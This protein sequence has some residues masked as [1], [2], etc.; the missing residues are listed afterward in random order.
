MNKEFNPKPN[1]PEM[2]EN[3]LKFWEDNKIFEKSLEQTK[4][5]KPFV[6]FE[7][8]PTANAKPALHHVE[9]RAFKDLIPRYQT[10]RGRFVNRKAGWDTHGLPVELQI[11]KKLQISGKKQIESIRPTVRESIIEFNRLCKQSV[12]EYK[13]DWEKLT[14]RMGYWVDMKN[15]YI[16]YHNKYI[17]SIWNI[18]KQAWDKDLVYLGHKV[19]PYCTRCGT[20]L[21]SHEVA[22]GYKTVK[23]NSVYV[24]FKLKNQENT[25]ILSWTTTPWTLPG[26]VALAVGKDIE[27][28]KVKVGDEFWILAKERLEA[29]GENPEVV[30]SMKGKDLLGLEYEPLFE[31]EFLKTPQSYKIYDADFVTTTDGTGVVHTAVVY[32]EDDYQLGEKVGL[33]KIHTVNDAGLFVPEV[34]ELAGMY[35]KDEA[36]EGKIFG[37]LKSH[38][39]FA[40]KEKY[41]H[42]YPHCWRCDTPLLYYARE[43]WFIK[44]SQLRED[45]IKNNEQ[46]TW[47]PSHIKYGRFGNWL[48]EI[49]DWAISRERYWGTPLPIWKCE[50]C[51][52]HQIIGSVDELKLNKNHFYIARHGEAQNVVQ[53]IHMHYP[54]T[55]PMP[56]TELGEKQ[57]HEL[58]EKIKALGGVDMIFASD[59]VRTKQTAE[60]A[61]K[62]L[63]VEVQFD[64]RLREF[65]TGVYNGKK[66]EEYHKDWPVQRRWQEAPE[67]GESYMDLQT[68]M[69]DFV[70]ELNSKHNGK[71]ILL[72]THG[73]V[74]WLMNQYYDVANH[75]PQV[76]EFTQIELGLTDLHRPYIDEVVLPCPYCGN[77]SKRV[78]SVLDVWFDSGAMPYAQW[79]AP[80]ENA[81]LARQQFP[82][83]FISEAID[84]TRGWFYT[85]LAIS[86]ILGKG[87]AYKHVICLG[88]LLD[89]KG[90][91]MSKSKGNIIDPWE[92]MNKQG[93]DAVRWYMYSIN[94][95]GD[96]KLFAERDLD[97]IVRKNFLTLWNVL[98]FFV[99]YSSFDKW[100]PSEKE[101]DALDVLDQWILAKT[102]ELVNSVTESL[103]NFDAFRAS[104]SIEDFINELS[105]WYVRRSRERKGPAVYQ[106]LYKVL[107]TLSL[108]MAPFTPFLAENIWQV[109][110]Q[111]N[112]AESVHL[113]VWPETRTLSADETELL[114]AM[115]AVREAAS[116][117]LNA[118][119]E[120]GLP[121]RQPLSRLAVQTKADVQLSPEL[122]AILASEVNVKLVDDKLVSQSGELVKTYAGTRYVQHLY[123]DTEI[124]PELKLEGLAR[125]LERIVQDMRKKSGLKVGE[126]VNLAYDTSDE[127][128]AKAMDLFDRK[129]T[130]VKEVSAK[131]LENEEPVSLDG[132]VI[133]L[134]IEK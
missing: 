27:Y 123:L 93:V 20:A 109:L 122:A 8:P 72:V 58:G 99:T 73:D 46:I 71:K 83:D 75:Y 51:K 92:P 59:L 111:E 28:A 124:S 40:R 97:L 126:M 33:P 91:K 35:V 131:N 34:K 22:Q 114:A 116:V 48:A 55:T 132:K 32:G 17:E 39:N 2:E 69:L 102:Q 107:K 65:N 100:T 61:G 14:H 82:A 37:H 44:M 47:N 18:L 12:W 74:I 90:L 103:D 96:S 21:S 87:P 60:I 115:E 4:D 29:A 62:I 110:R 26:N 105:T 113:A 11:E 98:S 118:R 120:L 56:L 23:D 104:R 81:N 134:A 129:K 127:E 38:G 85:L 112:D 121:I 117:A 63:G 57:A 52:K 78:P 30:A 68:R 125:N 5:G 15:P 53:G 6:F 77:D 88:H 50:H 41:E 13:D 45:L 86:T 70:S 130:F 66:L 101:T 84:Q 54:E 10:M 79:H 36:T 108:L 128:L 25:Y 95:P 89:E 80:F 19:L 133:K 106:T 49:K 94:Q 1:F 42:E 31:V 16:T 119:K 7:G 43:S 64:P 76:G 3:V 67:G 24:K 9:A